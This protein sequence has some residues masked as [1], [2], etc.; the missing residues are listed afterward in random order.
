MATIIDIGVLDHFVPLFV[1]LFVFVIFYAVLLKTKILGSNKG[2]M[3]LVSFVVAML[4]IITQ[5]A[6][7]FVQLVTPWFVVLIMITMA[8]LL[9]FMFMGIKP[10]AI[11]SAI[12]NESMVWTIM[13]VLL[14]LLGFALTKTIGPGIADITQ[15]N[16]DDENFV[17]SVGTILFHP[18]ILGV[19]FILFVA[20]F[21]I[22]GIA[23]AS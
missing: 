19:L 14:V 20:S 4:F 6:T 11:A 22:K 16:V 12:G 5:S 10:D 15:G 3:S 7:E 9:I 23:R 18:K 8:F 13:I 17:G 21:A 1:F 2:L